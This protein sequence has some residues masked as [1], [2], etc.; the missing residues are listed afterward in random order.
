MSPVGGATEGLADALRAEHAAIYAYGV[1]G[2]RLDA[3]TVALAT[4]AETAHRVRRDALVVRLS[5][6]GA[7]LPPAE[8]AYTL[9]SP[10][11][12]QHSALL[13]AVIIEERTAVVWRAALSGTLGEDRKLGLDALIDCAVRAT[14]IRRA[15]G[16]EQLTVAFP[17][18]S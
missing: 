4:G 13:L 15:A 9:P 12:D 17:G 18:Q 7:T 3:A 2:A 5:G 6:A 11:T 10:V 14:R 1:L 16:V 8:P